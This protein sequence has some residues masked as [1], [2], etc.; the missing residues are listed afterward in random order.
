MDKQQPG[1]RPDYRWTPRRVVLAALIVIVGGGFIGWTVRREAVNLRESFA[2]ER[3]YRQLEALVALD[4][5]TDF[6]IDNLIIPESDIRFGGPPRDG[7]PSLTRPEAVAAAAAD[8]LDDA[9]RVIGVEIGGAA[10]A[11]PVRV[12]MYHEAINDRLGDVPIAVIYCPLCD[13]VSVVDRRLDGST[14]EFGISGLVYNSN[15]L[16]YDRSDDSLWS[17]VGFTAISG[18]NAGR[19]LLHLPWTLTTLAAWRQVHPETTVVSLNT[20]H[21]RRYDQMPYEGYF[22]SDQLRFPVGHEDRRLERKDRI[23]GVKLDDFVRAYPVGLIAGAPKGEVRDV[24]GGRAIVLR[25]DPGTG[26]VRVVEAPEAA[27]VVHTF[28]FAWA[29]FHPETDIYKE[30]TEARRHEGTE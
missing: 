22:E 21:R 29:A 24:V 18:P 20:G 28:W 25:S 17:Q 1:K 8:F 9:D 10:R 2:A 3:T 26:E 13:S 12:L 11:Y 23:V 7:I 6:N 27:L 14:R 15:V 16:L 4:Q 19:S 30:G 5:L